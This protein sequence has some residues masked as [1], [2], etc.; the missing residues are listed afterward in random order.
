MSKDAEV[1]RPYELPRPLYALWYDVGQ[2]CGM[3]VQSG[4]ATFLLSKVGGARK[5]RLPNGQ[6]VDE[7]TKDIVRQLAKRR[8]FI[9]IDL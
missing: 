9:F 7:G 1:I 8:G 6:E 2:E 4:F 5:F 3:N